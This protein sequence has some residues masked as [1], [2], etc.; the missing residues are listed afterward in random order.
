MVSEAVELEK[1]SG[2]VELEKDSEQRWL[3]P[4]GLGHRQLGH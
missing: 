3:G 4:S 2:A 1:D